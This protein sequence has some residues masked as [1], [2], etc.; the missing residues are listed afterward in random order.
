MLRSPA[1]AALLSLISGA[2]WGASSPETDAQWDRYFAVWANDATAT[3]QAVE[4]LYAARVN[5]YGHE[6]TAAEVYR[7]KLYLMRQWPAR[8]YRVRP[9]TV[10]ASCSED[11]NRCR[12]NVVLDFLSANPAR[13]AGVMG[14]VSLSLLLAGP[15]GQ[16]KIEDENG[17]TVLRSGCMLAG[18]DWRAMS[19]WQCA[20]Y[21]FP[22]L[23]SS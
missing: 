1:A 22:P 6:M 2:A 20:P 17:A 21:R 5:Y 16:K 15:S 3:P 19:N 14:T 9:G 4:A 18:P 13:R 23:P 10:S 7:D 8:I 11:D 12:V